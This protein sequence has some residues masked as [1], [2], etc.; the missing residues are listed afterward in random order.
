MICVIVVGALILL[1]PGGYLLLKED[2]DY[3]SD[4]M[5]SVTYGVYGYDNGEFIP[6]PL[7]PILMSPFRIG[8]EEYSEIAPKVDWVSTGE[9]ID[10]TTFDLNGSMEVKYLKETWTDVPGHPDGGRWT[11][12]W[13]PTGI[14]TFFDSDAA[15][16]SWYKVFVLGTDLCLPE[17]R[18]DRETGAHAGESGWGYS[19]SGSVYGTVYDDFG[20]GPLT[21]SASFGGLAIWIT[22]VAG[23]GITATIV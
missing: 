15:S 6:I 12:S 22:Y 1:S 17:H 11:P 2:L 10:W 9:A 14:I 18:L 21:D 13:E 20:G 23:Y 3:N 7:E 4:S 8:G 5:S 16:G 19:F